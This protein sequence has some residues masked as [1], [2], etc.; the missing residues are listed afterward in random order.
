MTEIDPNDAAG[1]VLAGQHPD[2][3]RTTRRSP[4][5]PEQAKEQIAL[6]AK[7]L[8]LNPYLTPALY[9]LAFAYRLHGDADEAEG[10]A[11]P[12]AEDQ[13]RSPGTVA[14]PGR[15]W[16]TRCTA[17]WASM[18]RVVNPFPRARAAAETR[19]AARRISRPPGRCR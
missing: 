4:P 18:R 3:T 2:R 7:A 16:P 6:F 9:K 8:E 14:R 12:L 11:R 10:A 19:G 13:P 15:L 5:G 1:L 17:R